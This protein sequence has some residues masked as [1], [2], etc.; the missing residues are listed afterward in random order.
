MYWYHY[1]ALASSGIF[2]AN[3]CYHLIRLIRSGKPYDYAPGAGKTGPAIRYSFT[4]AMS[5][6]KKES[7]YLHL[8]SYIAG[9]IYH[10]GSFLSILL[11]ILNWFI[12]LSFGLFT[13]ILA[14]CLLVSVCCGIGILTKRIID[15]NLKNLSN[16]DDYLSNILVTSFQLLTALTLI[17]DTFTPVYYIM[18]SLLLLYFPLGKLKHA[19]YFFA[20]RYHLGFFYGW[21]GVWPPQQY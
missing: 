18:S 13:G 17:M 4:G 2:L 8:P 19:I 7:A 1:I 11:F 20:A 9:I 14:I 15:I 6:L 3:F 16:P 21:R 12:N 5:P 10:L